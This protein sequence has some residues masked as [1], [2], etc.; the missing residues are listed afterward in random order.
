[1]RNLIVL[2]GARPDVEQS[3]STYPAAYKAG[4]GYM[5]LTNFL[6]NGR[7]GTYTLHAYARDNGG[8]QVK[9]GSKTITC[10]NAHADQPFDAIDTP[11][12][13]GFASG[14]KYRN[15][16][17]VLTPMPNKIPVSG[18]TIKV[19]IDGQYIGNCSYNI[20][21]ED[22]LSFFPGYAN[23]SGAMALYDFDTTVYKNEIHTI[24]WVAT[25]NAGNTDGIGSRYFTIQ[26]SGYT[27]NSTNTKSQARLTGTGT[28]WFN[29]AGQLASI[30]LDTTRP[31]KITTGFSNQTESTTNTPT[32]DGITQISIP[33]DQRLVID[34]KLPSNRSTNVY[35]QV[36]DHL[37]PL[38]PGASLDREKGFFYW[39]PGPASL[40]KYSL[41]FIYENKTGNT[42][43]KP[44]NIVITTKNR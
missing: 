24:Q 27:R 43:K 4:W 16:G 11:A 26:N 25:D 6:P 10:D 12:Q 32:P 31:V 13:G 18:S 17:W 35:M 21:R 29:T 7:N 37:R 33:Q 3:Y 9:L 14:T 20:L 30:P 41:I 39:Q 22:I 23:S 2:D 44:V 5:M 42:V 19:Y 8:N 1:M 36:G 40:G 34:M 38:P 28:T 15:Q